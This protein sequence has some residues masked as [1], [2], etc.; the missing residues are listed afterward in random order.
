[1]ERNSL[2]LAGNGIQTSTGHN[3]QHGCHLV[4][5]RLGVEQSVSALLVEDA[6]NAV[7]VMQSSVKTLHTGL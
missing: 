6:R 4:M 5:H 7:S 2:R 1:M 3:I